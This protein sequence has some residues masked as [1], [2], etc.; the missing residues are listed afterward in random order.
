MPTTRIAAPNASKPGRH[1]PSPWRTSRPAA[2]QREQRGSSQRSQHAASCWPC[3][4]QPGRR[5]GADLAFSL[6]SSATSARRLSSSACSSWLSSGLSAAGPGLRSVSDNGHLLPSSGSSRRS[7][8]PPSRPLGARAGWPRKRHSFCLLA[9]PGEI[10]CV[11]AGK[12]R[13]ENCIRVRHVLSLSL[14]AGRY[15]WALR[16]V[17]VHHPAGSHPGR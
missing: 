9:V 16:P 12:G 1:G 6:R 2:G 13:I 8:L 4:R 7:L 14:L 17:A 15:S 3:A 11:G 10:I 5:R